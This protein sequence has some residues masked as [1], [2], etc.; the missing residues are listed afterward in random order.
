MQSSE[1]RDAP[2]ALRRAVGTNGA[3]KSKTVLALHRTRVGQGLHTVARDTFVFA[4]ENG[5]LLE[6]EADAQSF[7]QGTNFRILENCT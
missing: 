4:R 6:R 1:R 2:A 7:G 3:W 5:T